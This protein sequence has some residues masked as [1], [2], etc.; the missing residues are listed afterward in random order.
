MKEVQNLLD[1]ETYKKIVYYEY[2][3][4]SDLFETVTN[5]SKIDVSNV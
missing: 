2:K 3:N 1:I 4:L 5:T